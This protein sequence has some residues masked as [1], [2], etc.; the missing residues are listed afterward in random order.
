MKSCEMSSLRSFFFFQIE[1]HVVL[2]YFQSY[3][4]SCSVRKQKADK[5][6]DDMS[7]GILFDSSIYFPSTSCLVLK[8]LISETEADTHKEHLVKD[9]GEMQQVS[10]R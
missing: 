2:C 7:H 9:K 3:V 4:I 8:V 1:L 10:G 6:Q 5:S